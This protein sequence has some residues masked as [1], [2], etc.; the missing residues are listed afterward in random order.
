MVSAYGPTMQSDNK[1]MSV[2]WCDL[3]RWM[4]RQLGN[5]W[6]PSFV[7]GHFNCWVSPG[8]AYCELLSSALGNTGSYSSGSNSNRQSVYIN[9]RFVY[10]DVHSL[11]GVETHTIFWWSL[12][13][14][15]TG[16]AKLWQLLE[17]SQAIRMSTPVPWRVRACIFHTKL[18]FY[19]IGTNHAISC[20]LVVPLWLEYISTGS[21]MQ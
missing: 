19:D 18:F 7:V 8:A 6:E 11:P 9:Q 15:Q 1:M 16:S 21:S 17:L 12:G 4:A 5:I 20:H 3:E 10:S 14:S 2:C 13:R